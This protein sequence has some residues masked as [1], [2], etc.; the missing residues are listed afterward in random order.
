MRD[1]GGEA[2]QQVDD[3][4]YAAH[5]DGAAE[6][7]EQHRLAAQRGEGEAVQEPGLDVPGE[8]RAGGDRD[9]HRALDEREREQER[10]VVVRREPGYL[11]DAA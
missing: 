8:A 4:L 3:R 5:D 6:L 9:E 11:R 7:S 1:A 2:D 10:A